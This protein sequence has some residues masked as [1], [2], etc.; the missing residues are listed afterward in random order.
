MSAACLWNG[1]WAALVVVELRGGSICPC[2][3]DASD[4]RR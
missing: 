2:V 3:S 4:V 1:D